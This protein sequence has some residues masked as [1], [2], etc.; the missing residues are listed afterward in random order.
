MQFAD[1]LWFIFT[2]TQNA[3]DNSNEGSHIL[4]KRGLD[5]K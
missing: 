3:Q 1:V 5:S 4:V 2:K